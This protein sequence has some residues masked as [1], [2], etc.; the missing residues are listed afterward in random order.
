[1]SG[2]IKF[3]NGATL[4]LVRG[5]Q[6]LFRPEPKRKKVMADLYRVTPPGDPAP[7]N[8]SKLCK[9]NLVAYLIVWKSEGDAK[10]FDPRTIAFFFSGSKFDPGSADDCGRYSYDAAKPY[11]RSPITQLSQSLTVP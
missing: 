3:Q 2:Q 5:G 7:E 4:A 11:A 10:R 6:M 8:G 1:M 9:G